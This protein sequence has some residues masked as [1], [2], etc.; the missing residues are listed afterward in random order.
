MGK[1][2][3]LLL[4]LALLTTAKCYN[5]DPAAVLGAVPVVGAMVAKPPVTPAYVNTI[6]TPAAA[7]PPETDFANWFPD[8][9]KDPYDVALWTSVSNFLAGAHTQAGWT[10]ACKKVGGAAGADRA[11]KPL[12]GALACSGDGTVTGLQR[13]AARVLQARAA[14]A[15]Y[16][17]GA[18]GAGIGAV[19]GLQGEI[20]VACTS[21]VPGRQGGP[22]SPFGIACAKALDTSYLTGDLAATFAALGD[23]YAAASTEIARLA[24]AIDPEPG[25]FGPAKK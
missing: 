14:L 13:F 5:S 7:T 10:E 4:S 9:P 18:P 1:V 3:I 16:A 12:L 15:L 24:P 25:F 23:A 6:G 2:V 8:A 17:K 19:Q 22:D 11:A 21:D 20:R